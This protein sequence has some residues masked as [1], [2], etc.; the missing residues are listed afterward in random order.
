MKREFSAGGIVYYQDHQ[1]TK[2]LLIKNMAMRDLSKSYWGFP[3]GHLQEKEGSKE[4][5]VREVKEEVGI[6]AEITAKVGDSRYVF[7]VNGEKIFKVVIIF[8]M[9]APSLD[10]KIQQEE[11]QEARWVSGDE[12][13]E[14]LSFSNDK[15]LFK[16]ALDLL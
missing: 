1:A 7:S 3:K 16:Q 13:L 4:A 6:E 11:I 14:L 2:F 9:K 5:A 10:F 8:L 12:A 15:K